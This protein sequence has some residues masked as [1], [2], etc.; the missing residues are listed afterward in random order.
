MTMAAGSPDDIGHIDQGCL[1]R[2]ALDGSRERLP[3][4]VDCEACSNVCTDIPLTTR[5]PKQSVQLLTFKAVRYRGLITKL[6]FV[7]D[8]PYAVEQ[9]GCRKD[10]TRSESSMDRGM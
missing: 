5:I 7:R 9:A 1:A 10:G 6:P 4:A 2:I 3:R 8:L